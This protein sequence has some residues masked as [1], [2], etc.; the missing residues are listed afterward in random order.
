MSRAQ[1]RDGWRRRRWRGRSRGL[2]GGAANLR[3]ANLAIGALR[4]SRNKLVECTQQIRSL[5]FLQPSDPVRE[6]VAGLALGQRETCRSLLQ[7]LDHRL[8]E[9][10]CHFGRRHTHTAQTLWPAA[11]LTLDLLFSDFYPIAPV[12]FG[13]VESSVGGANEGIGVARVR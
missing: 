2:A 13:S 9:R 8:I 11:F 10:E 3:R 5:P 4:N 7:P 1:P 6:I 12:A